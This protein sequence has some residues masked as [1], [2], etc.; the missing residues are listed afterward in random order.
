MKRACQI[1]LLLLVLLMQSAPLMAWKAPAAIKCPMACCAWLMEAG[2][3]DCSCE[4]TPA[5]HGEPQPAP[6]PA[7]SARDFAPQVV[8]VEQAV[9]PI[10]FPSKGQSTMPPGGDERTPVSPHVRLTVLFCSFLT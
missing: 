3:G 1:F 7:S 4:A 6:L 9:L 5:E 10:T 2:L 8:W